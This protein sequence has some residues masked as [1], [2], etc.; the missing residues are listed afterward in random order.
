MKEK[1]TLEGSLQKT[2]GHV[3]PYKVRLM[4]AAGAL[5]VEEVGYRNELVQQNLEAVLGQ[6]KKIRET[7]ERL[8]FKEIIELLNE[9]SVPAGH[10]RE[11][12]VAALRSTEA[13]Y[14]P[15]SGRFGP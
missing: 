6:V 3:A 5:T 7:A 4:M 10:D 11:T 9:R 8:G 2:L 12:V 14:N 1:F 13:D 15:L